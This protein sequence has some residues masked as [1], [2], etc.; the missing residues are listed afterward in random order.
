M[1]RPR[2][3]IYIAILGTVVTAMAV[4]LATRL[5]FKV[6]VVRDRGAL[7]RI[8]EGGRIENVYR[9]QL[10]NAAESQQNFHISVAGLPEV[11]VASEQDVAIESTQARWV[12][13]RVQ[14]PFEAAPADSH[15]IHF[16]ITS[17]DTA[18]KLL[19]KSVFIVPR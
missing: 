16:E 13:V 6:D 2:V 9:L 12:A 4:S 17:K 1:L 15:T 18:G 3:L 14:A 8:V 19:E 7:A 5:P 10:M 11:A